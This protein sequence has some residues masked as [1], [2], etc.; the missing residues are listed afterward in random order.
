MV[1][2]GVGEVVG[3]FC[4][5]IL[6]DRIGSRRTIYANLA[7]LLIV[8]AVTEW[9][10]YSMKYDWLSFFMCFAWGFEDGTANTYV[11]QIL[12]FEF[13]G[14]GDPFA[15][16]TLLQGLSVFTFDLIEGAIQDDDR[17]QLLIYTACVVSVGLVANACTFFFKFKEG[18][19]PRTSQS[20]LYAQTDSGFSDRLKLNR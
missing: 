18:R 15:V 16:F 12:G 9:S 3:G 4:H 2:F 17:D 13:E 20:T 10:I 8:A 1:A 14:K 5:G 11:F 6:I 7:I 19:K